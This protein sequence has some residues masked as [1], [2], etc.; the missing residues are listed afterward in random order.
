MAA[1]SYPAKWT[2][3]DLLKAV[4]QLPPQEVDLFYTRLQRMR[5]GQRGPG[6]PSKEAA[7]LTQINRGFS[8]SWWKH[9]QQLLAKRREETLSKDEHRDLVRLTS[10]IENREVRRMQALVALA[11]LRKQSLRTLMK[12]LGLSAPSHA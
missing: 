4:E 3:D 11:G 7:L 2:S 10:Q 5:S 6:L 9:Y 8:E 12:N 1:N